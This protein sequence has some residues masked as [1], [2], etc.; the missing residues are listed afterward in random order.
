MKGVLIKKSTKKLFVL[1]GVCF[2]FNALLQAQTTFTEA[3][4]GNVNTNVFLTIGE[5]N[6]D[7]SRQTDSLALVALYDSTNGPTWKIKTNWLTNEPLETWYGITIFDERV[8][9]IVLY[10]NVLVGSIPPEIGNLSN[11]EGLDLESNNL[12][13]SIP[14]EIGNLSNL[15]HLD[16]SSNNLSASIPFEIAFL[17]QLTNLLLGSNQ[18]SGVISPAIGSLLKLQV[19]TINNNQ[20]TGSIPP[21]FYNLNRLAWLDLSSNNLSGSIPPE[22]GNLSNLNILDLGDNIFLGSI[23]PEIGNLNNLGSFDIHSNQFTELPG[24]SLPRLVS[25]YIQENKFTFEDI[26]P[27]INIPAFVYAPQ[28]RVG[29]EQ[30]IVVK[31]DSSLTILVTVGGINNQY[32]WYHDGNQIPGA[33]KDIYSKEHVDYSDIGTYICQISNTIATD[34]VLFSRPIHVTVE[35]PAFQQDSLALVALYNS[36]NGADWDSSGNWLSE[37]SIAT[38]YG[39]TVSGERITEIKLSDNNLVGPIPPEIGNLSE[40]IRL[41]LGQNNL[42]GVIPDRIVSLIKLQILNLNNNQLSGPILSYICKLIELEKIYL[43]SNQFIGEIP[44]KIEGLTNLRILQ[45]WL[46]EFEG[47]IPSSIGNLQYLEKLELQSNNLSGAIPESIGNLNN[48][49]WLDIS[50]NRIVGVVPGEIG[51]LTDLEFLKL[52]N[53]LLSGA[54]PE[55]IGSLDDLFILD[56]SKNQLAGVIPTQIKDLIN[57]STLN[58]SNNQFKDIPELELLTTLHILEMQNNEFTFEDIEPNINLPDSVIYWP[59]DSVGTRLDTTVI[60]GERIGLLVLVGGENNQYQWYKN[61]QKIIDSTKSSFTIKNADFSNMGTYFCKITNTV[62]TKLTLISRPVNVTVREA[63]P[64]IAINPDTL[65]FG[66][67]FLEDSSIKIVTISNVGEDILSVDSVRIAGEN[68]DQFSIDKGGEPFSIARGGNPHIIE[69]KFLPQSI[70]EKSAS[71]NIFSND[72][73]ESQTDVEL[74]AIGIIAP[75]VISV[76]PDS[77]DFGIFAVPFDTTISLT[78]S[79]EGAEA[80]NIDRAEFLGQGSTLFSISNGQ[81]P[82]IILPDEAHLMGIHLAVSTVDNI[83][84]TFR[85]FSNDPVKEEFNVSLMGSSL[86]ISTDSISN[87][88]Q[89]IATLHGTMNPGGNTLGILFEYGNTLSYG[90]EIQANQSTASGIED[91]SVNAKLHKLIP[92]TYYYFRMLA[93][94]NNDTIRGNAQTFKTLEPYDSTYTLVHTYSYPEKNKTSD[95]DPIE[96]QIIGLPG[97]SNQPVNELI[98]GIHGEDWQLYGDNGN[99][100]DDHL[101]AYERNK[102]YKFFVGKAFWLI[103]KGN[104]IIENEIVNTAPLNADE[105]VSIPLQS[106]WNL[107]SNPFNKKIAWSKIVEMNSNSLIPLWTFD[108]S[109]DTTN[110]FEPFKGYYFENSTNLDS[111]KIPYRLLFEEN[112]NAQVVDPAIWRIHVRYSSGSLVDE[113][114]SFGIALDSQKGIDQFDFRKPRAAIDY[115]SVYFYHQNQNGSYSAFATDI[116]PQFEQSET[117]EIGTKTQTGISSQLS[118]LGIENIPQSLEIYL[119]V[120]SGGDSINLR[121]QANYNFIP[122]TSK[123]QFTIVAGTETAVQEKLSQLLPEQFMLGNNYPNPFNLNTTIPIEIPKK[124]DIS[125]EIFNILGKR[126]NILFSG[127]IEHGKYSFNWNG[128]DHNNHSV[129]SGVYIYRITSRQGFIANHKM[130]LLK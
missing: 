116:R 17:A 92:D 18:F 7:L 35:L 25:L 105:E 55:T 51:S 125:L 83:D 12:S 30:D 73:D 48:L 63:R 53:N 40:L 97:A 107:I 21:E 11:L 50:G 104:F 100:S 2:L 109:F 86:F 93:I 68:S 96:Y 38:W 8:I 112:G 126:I 114:V 39:I 20:L 13:G 16:L 82:I 4:S 74:I 84:A 103:H 72:F 111:L 76:E 23:P 36:T 91:V 64:E 71:L 22:I 130:V 85:I 65:N 28:D 117:W 41:E 89:K 113:T 79:N 59:Q 9:E 78:I 124:S 90:N 15:T 77:I 43:E 37:D 80:L 5:T 31:T 52:S 88:G 60:V 3:D 56:L 47:S 19:L 26:E 27:N 33:T 99:F 54:L 57:L 119:F 115:P 49:E 66:Y 10:E 75:P 110:N 123:Y 120:E 94:L 6:A 45:L 108:K 61:D 14:S 62:A 58:I 81:L 46:N 87:K 69:I 122:L 98:S 106:G 29:T 1:F 129:A 101:V 24:F 70:G 121:Q 95:Y 128:K 42:T 102:D 67:V 118:F 127:I 32:Q 44:S 34:L